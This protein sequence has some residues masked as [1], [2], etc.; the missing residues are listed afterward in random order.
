LSAR[1]VME[2]VGVIGYLL[3]SVCRAL[4]LMF[5]AHGRK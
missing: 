5:N 2:A 1:I 3:V 4:K